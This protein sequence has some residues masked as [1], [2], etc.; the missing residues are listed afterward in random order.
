MAQQMVRR[1]VE[2]IA[3]ARPA[4]RRRTACWSPTACCSV[5]PGAS[6]RS[7]SC[8]RRA[9]KAERLT[10]L[11]GAYDRV[12]ARLWSRR[13]PA[14]LHREPGADGARLP[15]AM[16][17]LA[18]ETA[19]DGPL[20]SRRRHGAQR[21]GAGAALQ[22][23]AG[24]L[25]LTR[26]FRATSTPRSSKVRLDVLKVLAALLA[27]PCCCRSISP[28]P[29]PGRSAG[30]PSPPSACAAIAIAAHTIPDFGRRSDEIG[31]LAGA[32]SEMTE[33]LWLRMDAI[34]RFAADV[35]HEIE[36]PAHLAAQ[37][38]RDG[39]AGQRSRSAGKS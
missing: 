19:S 24:A 27:S 39:G 37:R 11:L 4:V 26:E 15:E 12:L 10:A 7:R 8:R 18:G 31:Q 34:E 23:G 20:R 9:P 38:G 25:M 35:A 1:L 32:L 14:D 5:V 36:E 30:S 13:G 21:R 29:S 28:A 16:L 17:A 3:A 33:A 6:C 22:A 2:T